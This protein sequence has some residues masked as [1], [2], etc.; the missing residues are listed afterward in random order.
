[1]ESISKSKR[2]RV[3]HPKYKTRSVRLPEPMVELVKEIGYHLQVLPQDGN[4]GYTLFEL[5]RINHYLREEKAR[6]EANFRQSVRQ[7]KER[8]A[9]L[10]IDE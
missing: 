8:Q 1:M 6:I 4:L 2:K 7:H 3:R 10:Y 9:T 5:R